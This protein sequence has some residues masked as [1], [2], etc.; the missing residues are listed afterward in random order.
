[1]TVEELRREGLRLYYAHSLDEALPFFDQALA[2]AE[3]DETRDLLTIHKASIH[4]AQERATPEVAAL[5]AIIMRRRE[6][7]GLAA[8]HLAAKFENEKDYARARFYLAIAQ[9]AAEESDDLRL[10]VVTTIDL[11]NLCVYDSQPEE[12]LAYYNS[13]LALLE[14]ENVRAVVAEAEG[15]LWAAF[16]TQN[17]GYCNVITD[18]AEAGVGLLHRAVEMLG[19]CDGQAYA[20]ESQ[21]DLCL[22]YLELGQLD[23]ARLHGEIGLRDATEDRQVRNGHFLLGEI[24]YTAGDIA[25]AEYH[26]DQL[27]RFYPDFP[28]LRNLLFAIDLRKMVNFRL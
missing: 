12:A 26:F 15:A 19:E 4:I 17:L 9:Q 1:M 13:A 11:G 21:L 25:R 16:A 2:L 18:R 14:K 10:T 23:K 6:L 20:A 3:D 7:R 8:Y 27:A 28:Q 24:A 22:G 5:P